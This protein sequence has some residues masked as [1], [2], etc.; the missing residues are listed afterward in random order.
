MTNI[1]RWRTSPLAV[2]PAE[3]SPDY[4]CTAGRDTC[5]APGLDPIH[6]FMDYSDDV[7]VTEFT[8]GQIARM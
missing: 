4:H 7:C 2:T 5:P 1:T 6:N 3:Q 8:P